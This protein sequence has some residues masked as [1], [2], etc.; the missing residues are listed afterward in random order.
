MLLSYSKNNLPHAAAEGLEIDRQTDSVNQAERKWRA[1]GRLQ[2]RNK[3]VCLDFKKSSKERKK[4]PPS[5]RAR[6]PG[7]WGQLVSSGAHEYQCLKICF[8]F[9]A[10]IFFAG[11]VFLVILY[12]RDVEFKW[13]GETFNLWASCLSNKFCPKNVS[14]L[15]KRGSNFSP[16]LHG[17]TIF[18]VAFEF[19]SFEVPVQYASGLKEAHPH[20]NLRVLTLPSLQVSSNEIK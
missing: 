1:E 2:I 19:T 4:R 3:E 13:P 16:G 14:V 17:S 20:S 10:G 15:G 12:S 8:R 9:L 7:L 5:K 6:K 18:Q 11:F